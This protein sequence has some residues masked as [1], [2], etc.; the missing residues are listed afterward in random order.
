ME[1]HTPRR[2]SRHHVHATD[3]QKRY[4]MRSRMWCHTAQSIRTSTSRPSRTTSITHTHHIRTPQRLRVVSHYT[5]MVHLRRHMED[6]SSSLHDSSSNEY[7]SSEDD[8]TRARLA[9]GSHASSSSSS[10]SSDSS[11]KSSTSSENT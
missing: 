11:S 7:S 2:S 10:P 4:A 5:G 6:A 8:D 9:G 3:T 1:S